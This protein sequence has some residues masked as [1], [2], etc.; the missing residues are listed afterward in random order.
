MTPEEALRGVTVNAAK[1]MGVERDVGSVE[2]GKSADL[3]LW[4]CKDAVDLS[5][6]LGFN[7]LEKV[8][9]NG[10]VRK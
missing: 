10:R 1:A 4:G 7:Q 9:V 8:W 2:V 6:Y 3:C 5:Y